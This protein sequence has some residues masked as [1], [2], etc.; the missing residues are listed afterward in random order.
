M[1]TLVELV[2]TEVTALELDSLKYTTLEVEV[3]PLG[4]VTTVSTTVVL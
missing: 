2:M 4:Y 1:V 3:A